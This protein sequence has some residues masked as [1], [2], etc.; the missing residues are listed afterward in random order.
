MLNTVH[1]TKASN[2]K[3]SFSS[4]TIIFQ[5]VIHFFEELFDVEQTFLNT[6]KAKQGPVERISEVKEKKRLA[7]IFLSETISFS[8]SFSFIRSKEAMHN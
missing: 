7:F 4:V 5:S 6:L 1:I 2:L 3:I 8:F